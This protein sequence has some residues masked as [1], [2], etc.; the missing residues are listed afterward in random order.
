MPEHGVMLAKHAVGNMDLVV[1]DLVSVS[2]HQGEYIIDYIFEREN[3][4]KRSYDKRTKLLSSNLS[5]LII[6]TQPLPHTNLS[7]IDRVLCQAT[8]ERIPVCLVLN[9]CDLTNTLPQTIK[10]LSYYGPITAEKVTSSYFHNE[11]KDPDEQI[12]NNI[13]LTSAIT[14]EGLSELSNCLSFA[15]SVGIENH[16]VIAITGMSG[17]GKSSLISALIP[18]LSLRTNQVATRGMGKQT[19]SQPQAYLWGAASDV[20]LVDL[21]GIQN[22][23]LTHLSQ[24]GVMQGFSDLA[25]LSLGCRFSNC[26]HQSDPGCAIR[27]AIENNL[28]PQSRLDNYF[29]II[30]DIKRCYPYGK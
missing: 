30:R 8:T 24:S 6:V 18:G 10:L 17:V 22:F 14:G 27:E 2:V 15:Q 7:F 12:I 23:G 1:G 25:K 11:Q 26:G 16:K 9:K 5:L 19:T 29:A 28:L 3:E 4:F 13:L 21:P 20:F